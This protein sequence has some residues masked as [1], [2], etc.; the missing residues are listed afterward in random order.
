MWLVKF[1][2]SSS[3]VKLLGITIDYYL[4]FKK[5]INKLCRKASYNKLHALQRIRRYLSVDKAKL[6]ANA[7]IESQRN[8]APLMWMFA[9]KTL[10]NKIC[11]IHHRTLQ[12]VYDDFNKLCDELLELNND[13][14]I[15]QRHLRY[16]A[17]EVFKSIMHLNPQFMWSYFEEKPMPYNLR[18]GSKLVL[19]KTKSSRFGINSLQFRGSFLWNNLPVS[20]KNCQSLNEFKRESKNLGNILCTCL[21]CR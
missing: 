10:I 14:S 2:S 13:L 19:P 4:K 1:I 9:G 6:L 20:L 17:I 3:E 5:H 16:L 21:V 18:D 11:K 15:H 8:H 12:L 7:F